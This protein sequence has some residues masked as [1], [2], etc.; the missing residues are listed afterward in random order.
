[1]TDIRYVVLL[2]AAL[3][4]SISPGSPSSAQNWPQRTVKFIVP[5]GPGAGV[6]IGARLFAEKLS[7]RWG[8]P[9]VVENRPGGD[10][11]VAITSFL[12]SDDHTLLFSP[13]AAFTAHP[14]QHEKVPY[15][16]ADLV[17]VARVSNTLVAVAVP[18]S[19]PVSSVR[20]LVELGQA[21]PGKLN[22]AGVTGAVD[23]T[24][25]AFLR[26]VGADIRKIPYRDSV[27]ALSDLAEGRLQLYVAAL[28][29]VRPQI[30]AGRVKLLA[31]T[32][33]ERAP[34]Y[35]N[36]PTAAEAGYPTLAFDGL[37]GV[38]SQRS[39]S[40]DLRARISQDILSVGNDPAI[41]SRLG[42][43]GQDVRPSAPE[44]FAA[45]IDKQRATVTAAAV[46]LGLKA[47]Q[48]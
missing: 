16:F 30:E 39:M 20:E 4:V 7:Q 21:Q 18:A 35:P 14:F 37:V 24:V 34:T 8:Q 27:Q 2:A 31:I 19:L 1:M 12:S 29:I 6:D 43:T 17:P 3:L 38:F 45:S 5:L 33:G 44:E 36:I 47:A 15:N 40:P 25:D 32:N 26:E 13:S 9:V 46:R 23:F 42:A 10:S 41:S 28:A 22:W 11:I 48:Q